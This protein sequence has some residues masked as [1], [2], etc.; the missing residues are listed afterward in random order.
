M[1]AWPCLWF[2]GAYRPNLRICLG[3]VAAT[4][5][6]TSGAQ[7]DVGWRVGVREIEILV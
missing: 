5:S 4:S 2:I 1:G 6:F 7:V 3:L